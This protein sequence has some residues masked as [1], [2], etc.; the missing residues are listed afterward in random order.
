MSK[1][2]AIE[3]PDRVGKATQ[4]RM[5][6]DHITKELNKKATVVEVPIRDGGTYK[7]IYWM[8]KNGLA[9]KFPKVFQW[10]Q[11]L[12]RWI[13]Q[14]TRLVELEHEYDYV[15]F[16]RWSCSSV[17]YGAA[18]GLNRRSLEKMARLLRAPDFTI[19]LLGDSHAHEAEDVYESDSVL[20]GRVSDLYAAWADEKP[21][22]AHVVPCNGAV[23]KVASEIKTVLRTMRHIPT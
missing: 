11:V 6:C 16:D 4:S 18:E 2:I 19:V 13:F 8:L 23:E 9:K 17:V 21:G 12:N 3:G 14:T 20:Q 10:L 15:I 22:K 1:I 7:I 5:L